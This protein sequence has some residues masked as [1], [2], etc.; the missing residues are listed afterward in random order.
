MHDNGLEINCW[1]VNS[2]ERGE[3]L[4]AMGVDYITTNILE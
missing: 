2:K 3:E 4:A 1:T